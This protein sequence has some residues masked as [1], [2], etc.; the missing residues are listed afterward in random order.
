MHA[1]TR[2]AMR[3]WKT[4][5][6]PPSPP[7][8]PPHPP[9]QGAALKRRRQEE[10]CLTNRWELSGGCGV[11]RLGWG[12]GGG[13][14]HFYLCLLSSPVPQTRPS[15]SSLSQ[16]STPSDK[17]RPLLSHSAQLDPPLPITPPQNKHTC[18]CCNATVSPLF[19]SRPTRQQRSGHG[20]TCISGLFAPRSSVSNT[21]RAIC[22]CQGTKVGPSS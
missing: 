6:P 2:V 10:Q 13:C 4:P 8:S 20:C 21:T 14:F 5:L 19:E 11:G 17:P 15:A 3:C 9:R 16:S 1:G 12:C 18:K 22:A 7:T